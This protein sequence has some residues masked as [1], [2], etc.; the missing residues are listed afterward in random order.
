[1][2]DQ[3]IR[4]LITRLARPLPSGGAVIERAAILAEGADAAAVLGWIADHGGRPEARAVQP[5]G[6]GL[7]SGRLRPSTTAAP[8]RRYVLPADWVSSD[9]PEPAKTPASTETI[10]PPL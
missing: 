4:L 9:A 3:E 1:M 6:G 10:T 7:H 5:A 8:V 2:E